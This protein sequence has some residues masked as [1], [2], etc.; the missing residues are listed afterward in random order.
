MVIPFEQN[1]IILYVDNEVWVGTKKISKR[2]VIWHLLNLEGSFGEYQGG[3]RFC[4]AALH[5]KLHA[6][7]F[8]KLGSGAKPPPQ[9]P[10]PHWLRQTK[11]WNPPTPFGLATPLQGGVLLSS[12]TTQEVACFQRCGG[13]L[14]FFKVL[15]VLNQTFSQQ[16]Q[17]QCSRQ[18]DIVDLNPVLYNVL[19]SL[20]SL[21]FWD[22]VSEFYSAA[23]LWSHSTMQ[24][25]HNIFFLFSWPG[26]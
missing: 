17:S 21:L 10:P 7:K 16:I 14:F 5:R 15:I 2:S 18:R 1:Y 8:S 20:F 22:H 11:F 12:S 25:K 19:L 6:S 9:T 26:Q 3:V 4:P 13:F 24:I 23:F